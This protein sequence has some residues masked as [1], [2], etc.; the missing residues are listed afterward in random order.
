MH[1]APQQA[2]AVHGGGSANGRQQEW[3]VQQHKRSK[4]KRNI[5][6]FYLFNKNITRT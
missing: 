2:Q 3:G 1:G 6:V 5:L 4:S